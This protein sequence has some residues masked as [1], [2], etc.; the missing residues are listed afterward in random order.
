MYGLIIIFLTV[1][2]LNGADNI[3]GLI[4]NID[5]IPKEPGLKILPTLLEENEELRKLY[6]FLEDKS[7]NINNPIV[8]DEPTVWEESEEYPEECYES[9]RNTRNAHRTE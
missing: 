8:K 9:S 3:E 5:N 2:M 6:F 4:G 7:E 1:Y